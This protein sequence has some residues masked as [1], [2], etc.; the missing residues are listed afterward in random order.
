MFSFCGPMLASK[1]WL[2][3]ALVIQHFNP[4]IKINE[5]S[6]SEDVVALTQAIRRLAHSG[7]RE[8]NY[9]LGLGGT[10]LRFFSFLVSR[11]V[12]DFKLNA[13]ERLMLR[14]QQEIETVLR[15][16][17]VECQ[18]DN[19][20]VHIRS[21]GWKIPHKPVTVSAS[22]SSQFISGLLL[23]CWDL[24]QGLI[25]EI[26]KPLLSVAYLDMTVDLL[27]SAGM[28]IM[29]KEEEECLFISIPPGQKSDVVELKAELDISS[30]FSLFGAAIVNGRAHITNW[31][32]QSYQPDLK[33]MEFFKLMEISY[34]VDG[35]DFMIE[36]QASW[37][38]LTA[39]LSQCPDL[40]PVLSVLCA[41]A[42]GDSH[43]YGAAQLQFK[44]SDRIEKTAELLDLAGFSF[45]KMSDGIKIKGR[46]ASTHLREVDFFP[47]HDH[48]MAMAAALLKLAG[49]KIN[50]LQPETVNK[51]YP[52]FWQHI[53]VA[54]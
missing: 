2:N 53:G 48:R 31:N 9:E 34:H 40:F 10:T 20:S 14:P 23:C 38:G 12:G 16:L 49:W 11:Q 24:P 27:K 41:L 17:G 3:R 25:I 4:H 18:V 29:L 44:E 39:D 8:Q 36:K 43:L 19:K 26:K 51:S 32:S 28:R 47:A 50:I 21:S 13:H 30:A 15:Q 54:P 52:T 33:M 35:A 37:K 7:G 22:L 1:S 6:Q 45:V 46:S 42:N 5:L